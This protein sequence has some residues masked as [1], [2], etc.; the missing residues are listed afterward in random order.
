MGLII[1]QIESNGRIF[2][3]G[4]FRTGDRI[5]EINNQSLIDVNFLRYRNILKMNFLF[6]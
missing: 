2:K 3:D 4:R 6:Y 1:Q 5:V